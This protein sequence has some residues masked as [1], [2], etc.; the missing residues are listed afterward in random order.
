LVVQ[1]NFIK[2]CEPASENP[3]LKGKNKSILNGEICLTSCNWYL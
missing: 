1:N 3:L 2:K